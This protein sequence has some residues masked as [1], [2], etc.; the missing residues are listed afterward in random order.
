MKTTQTMKALI[1]ATLAATTLVGGTPLLADRDYDYGRRDRHEDH[2]RDDHRHDYD[3][4]RYDRDRGR[5]D[6]DYDYDRRGPR[7]G[8]LEKLGTVWA[9][10]ALDR[11]VVEVRGRARFAAIVFRVDRGDVR[12]E[13]VKITFGNDSSYS[14]PTKHYFR[15]GERSCRIELPA[16]YDGR[17][18]KRVRFLYRS[19]DRGPA[20]IDVF[21]E[22]AL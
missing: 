16:G 9:G 17:D 6:H 5:H 3:R 10:K 11:D 7:R 22:L 14:P 20:V 13:D 21:G 19:A 4:G 1:A 12:M 2:R 15:E 8:E 18:I